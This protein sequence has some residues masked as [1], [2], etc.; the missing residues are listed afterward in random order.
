MAAG[1]GQGGGLRRAARCGAAEI[2]RARDVPLPVGA[3][4]HGPCAQLHDG[5]RDRALQDGHR[6]QRAA[7]DGLGRLRDAGRKRRD[8]DRRPSQDLDLRQHRRHARPDEAAGP[9]HRL[10]ARIRHLRS[11]VLRPAAGAVSRHA[12]GGPRLSQERGGQ[13]GPRRHDRAGQRAGDRRQGLALGRRGRAPRVDAMVLPDQR[14]G[15]GT[16]GGAGRARQ[17]ARQGAADAGELDRQV[18]RAADDL[19]SDRAVPRS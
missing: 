13:L 16:A 8:G 6:A 17:L 3:Y 4:P 15:R 19:P 1:L 7:P 11:G 9:Q 5:R 12:E 18:A 2:L 14:H 10:V